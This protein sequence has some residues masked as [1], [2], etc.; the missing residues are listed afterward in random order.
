MAPPLPFIPEDAHGTKVLFVVQ[1]YAGDLAEGE[2]IL[3]PL[4]EFGDPIADGVA[5]A[6]YTVAQSAMDSLLPKG[7]RYYWKS[8]NF[9]SL[10]DEVIDT[11]VQCAAK[12]PTPRSD[13]LIH[14][15]GGK[16]NDYAPDATAYPHRDTQ[17]VVTL[18]GFS[19]GS[20]QDEACIA[21]VRESHAALGEFVSGGAYV[22]F[23]SHDKDEDWLQAA[24]GDNIGRL[25]KIKAQ[26]DPDNFFR[27]NHNIQPQ[28]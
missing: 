20:Q 2:K 21:W 14:Q 22:N 13:I 27:M 25:Q 12:L 6:P 23:L 9:T 19:E 18:G 26:Y 17:F 3:K 24:Y 15:L 7:D 16:I 4:R 28:L 11:F 5:P 8:H 1:F 10:S